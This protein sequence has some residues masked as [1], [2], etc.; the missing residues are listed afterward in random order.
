MSNA[1]NSRTKKAQKRT[2]VKFATKQNNRS[3]YFR[4]G[5]RP[6]RHYEPLPPEEVAKQISKEDHQDVQSDLC[7]LDV[8][9]VGSK[10]AKSTRKRLKKAP[11]KKRRKALRALC[12]AIG[13]FADAK[14]YWRLLLLGLLS[15]VMDLALP[16]LPGVPVIL[17]ENAI[18]IPHA[19]LTVL[20]ALHG[21]AMLKEKGC[22]LRRP[23]YLRAQVTVGSSSPSADMEDYLGGYVRVYGVKKFLWIPMACV[24]YAIA[25]N[26]PESVRKTAIERSPLAIPIL[27]ANP[28]VQGRPVLTFDAASFQQYDPARL[29]KLASHA[30]LIYAE[31][32]AF[33][34]W[35]HKGRKRWSNCAAGIEQFLPKQRNGRFI[36]MAPS[37]EATIMAMA[38]SVFNTFLGYAYREG[39]IKAKAANA[40][41]AEAWQQVLP[42]SYPKMDVGNSDDT[43]ADTPVVSGKWNEPAVFWPFLERY[44][45]D[46][47]QHIDLDG[48]PCKRDTAAVVHNL[49]DAAYLICPR[50]QVAQ[51]YAEHLRMN[52][53][54]LPEEKNWETALQR[55]ILNWGVPVKTEKNDITWRFSFYEKDA[56]EKAKVP[57]LAFPLTQLPETITD[58]LTDWFGEA[59]ERWLP[60]EAV[61]NESEVEKVPESAENE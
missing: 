17:L 19:L 44:L 42:E 61:R 33:D 59:F 46:R 30:K 10:E 15:L 13:T 53:I 35:I 40:I 22:R 18:G 2:K 8:V 9:E 5:N 36:L 48:A 32:T 12:P 51:S 6:K 20:V 39:W 11:R 52:G 21:P 7:S 4:R 54:P 47:Q 26:L 24:M 34:H 58:S 31:L 23:Y 27:C 37:A 50:E 55:S 28:K 25:P 16:N 41:I 14:A 45:Q 38:L 56:A 29:K 60:P 57:C 3:D 1:K 43:T 49:A